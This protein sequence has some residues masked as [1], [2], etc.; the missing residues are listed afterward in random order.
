MAPRSTDA[1]GFV[2]GSIKKVIVREF[3]V[4]QYAEFQMH[5]A[6][7]MIIGPNGTGKSTVVCA[8]AV[9]LASSP[10]VTGRGNDV[11]DYVRN[12]SADGKAEVEI[13]LSGGSES[14]R[15]IVIK[16]IIDKG[17]KV[18][19]FFINGIKAKQKQVETQLNTLR[20]QVDNICQFLPQEKVSELAGLSEEELLRKVEDAA[21]PPNMVAKHDTL[22]A[23]DKDVH[24]L[25]QNVVH[26]QGE[27]DTLVDKNRAIENQYQRIRNR[28]QMRQKAAL[29]RVLLWIARYNQIRERL[30]ELTAIKQDLEATQKRL[31][32]ELAPME[33]DLAHLR[34]QSDHFKRAMVNPSRMLD[35]AI[36]RLDT[37]RTA[38][39]RLVQRADD[40]SARIV[41]HR[42][43]KTA[44]IGKLDRHRAEHE[45]LLGEY[46]DCE[47]RVQAN[48]EEKTRIEA[49]MQPI[50][51]RLTEAR[52]AA[53][54]A[55]EDLRSAENL[56]QGTRATMTELEARLH[57]L[58]QRGNDRYQRLS[59][60]DQNLGYAARWVKENADKF[61]G[62]VFGPLILELTPK[63]QR[64]LNVVE[65][66]VGVPFLLRTY[67]VEEA[68]DYHLL[69]NH[70][71]DGPNR[72]DISVFQHRMREVRHSH[73]PEQLRELGFETTLADMVTA[74]EFVM[75]YLC[76]NRQLNNIP[77]SPADNVNHEVV[78]RSG[79][80]SYVTANTYC[81]VRTHASDPNNP[82]LVSNALSG[83]PQW[84]NIDNGY[85][86]GIERE[87]IEGELIECRQRYEEINHKMQD[88]SQRL[89]D[90]EK[91][92]REIARE[93]SAYQQQ[94]K[95]LGAAA[96]EL[97]SLRRRV[98]TAQR[99]VAELEARPAALQVE[100]DRLERELDT[101]TTEKANAA[102]TVHDYVR[103]VP[104]YL[105][106]KRV[107]TLQAALCSSRAAAMAES[108]QDLRAQ[109][110]EC[111]QSL[112]LNRN[113]T[114]E[115]ARDARDIK[116]KW[117][118]ATLEAK[119]DS[120]EHLKEQLETLRA[121]YEL[122]DLP[123]AQEIERLNQHLDDLETQ[124]GAV[125]NTDDSVIETYETRAA[126]IERM[127]GQNEEQR[128]E[129]NAMIE[130]RNK[131]KDEWLP[132]LEE[133]LQTVST[134][135]SNYFA[136]IRCAGE[137]SLRKADKFAEYALEIR[138]KFRASQE[139]QVLEKSRQS[140]GERAVTTILFLLSLQ[141]FSNAPFRLV[142]EI[143]QGMDEHNERMIHKLL[144]ES[145][146]KP[147]SPQYFL[148]TP[149]LLCGLHY[150]DAM[151]VHC[152]FNG[153]EV[154]P[155]FYSMS[156]AYSASQFLDRA[157]IAATSKAIND[158]VDLVPSQYW[159]ATDHEQMLESRY[160]HKKRGMDAPGPKAKKA[161]LDLVDTTAVSARQSAMAKAASAKAGSDAESGS[162]D[163]DDAED[164]EMAEAD[165]AL[166]DD[167]SD[168]DEPARGPARTIK[169][170][171][172]ALS[173]ARTPTN[174]KKIA[175][176]AKITA[177]GKKAKR[178]EKKQKHKKQ[179]QID[180]IKKESND[181]QIL[182]KDATDSRSAGAKAS[183]NGKNK[184]GKSAAGIEEN[185]SFGKV[186]FGEEKAKKKGPANKDVRAQ[187]AKVEKEKERIAELAELNPEKAK[188][189]QEKQAWRK[190][191]LQAAGEKVK[192][193]VK[194]LKKAVKRKEKAKEKRTQ[195]WG[196]RKRT[197]DEDLQSR[198]KKRNDNINKRNEERKAKKMAS[199]KKRK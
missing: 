111:E 133:L 196:D 176:K 65:S 98:T 121:E 44:V 193:D 31:T 167:D 26:L 82:V 131:V 139:L 109:L 113:H 12:N 104:G 164:A 142:D 67:I 123:I 168:V 189:V 70:F 85:Q 124:L 5:P 58:R 73:T 169:E 34:S 91:E 143:N 107:A 178:E 72:V 172:A 149:K 161:K 135:F 183:A 170:H 97:T 35:D 32:E 20:I 90:R 69:A 128:A 132:V 93:R 179:R 11:W 87:H 52:L 16:R 51:D 15:P 188:A 114:Q 127:L 125:R 1:D 43:E 22:I 157:C 46:A 47:A 112:N 57:A 110:K 38:H 2:R 74:D 66:V 146:A 27:I 197:A 3:M 36:K 147:G 119:A 136:H 55:H 152:V 94:L 159:I 173:A 80:Q 102:L 68:D 50:N 88:R 83:V 37:F 140:G 42:N 165:D 92:A 162:D 56:E 6:L 71:V 77:Y 17:H 129:L 182:G 191:M 175:K 116:S 171:R 105:S 156:P 118:E 28:T 30:T 89:Q 84:L 25:E 86:A 39:Q 198:I 96:G 29:T 54:Q 180:Q 166:D 78:M 187:L 53:A 7:N 45:R 141:E 76:T 4:Y 163:D 21:G 151:R 158:L 186:D 120:K 194:L 99:Q 41:E 185:I 150:S 190:A 8:L 108:Q 138:V 24:E 48:A 115:R 126:E 13:H 160:H 199:K 153:N 137:V 155:F 64:G 103:R 177:E 18:S 14:P 100:L 59:Q 10:K 81:N 9:G 19:T 117:E 174:P 101:I 49:E 33:A 40:I 184:G 95:N 130:K 181:G 145:A 63:Q 62:R 154:D 148:I 23:L 75:N 192:D 79:L 134:N 144:V 60:H 122:A 195:E 106:A 61:K